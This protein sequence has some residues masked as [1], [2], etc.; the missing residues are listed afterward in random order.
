[1]KFHAKLT[2]LLH[3]FRYWE[4][5]KKKQLVPL[6]EYCEELKE[7][8]KKLEEE[9]RIMRQM[10]FEASRPEPGHASHISRS[11][12]TSELPK[13]TI[14]PTKDRLKALLEGEDT[15]KLNIYLKLRRL[16]LDEAKKLVYND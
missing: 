5:D 6:V 8:V 3:D 14:V 11:F 15:E 16:T 4:V 13:E 2:K 12:A 9:L 7:K 1:M 10:S